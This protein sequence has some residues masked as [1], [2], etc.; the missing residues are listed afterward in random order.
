M[1][2]LEHVCLTRTTV[3]SSHTLPLYR[4]IERCCMNYKPNLL[5][6]KYG[7]VIWGGCGGGNECVLVQNN[8]HPFAHTHTHSCHI[9]FVV[10]PRMETSLSGSQFARSMTYAHMSTRIWSMLT[11]PNV[12]QP[13]I[14]RDITSV[15]CERFGGDTARLFDYGYRNIFFNPLLFASC[16][17]TFSKWYKIT[18]GMKRSAQ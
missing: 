17:D 15:T 11:G 10:W 1:L 8:S 16:T 18:R 2:S 9:G 13:E 7:T 14:Y 12:K 3:H 4:Y 6:M 5:H